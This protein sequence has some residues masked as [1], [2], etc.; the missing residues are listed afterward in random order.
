[1]SIQSFHVQNQIMQAL[2]SIKLVAGDTSKVGGD[3]VSILHFLK[4][5]STIVIR[6][7][8]PASP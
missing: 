7:G 6:G 1:M 5:S 8:Y 4:G 3:D 2:Q